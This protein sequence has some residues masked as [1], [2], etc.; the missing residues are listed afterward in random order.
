MPQQKMLFLTKFSTML[1][2]GKGKGKA[3]AMPTT[4]S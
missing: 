2:K 4:A 1:G 3:V